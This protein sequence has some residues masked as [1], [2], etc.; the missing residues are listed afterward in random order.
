MRITNQMKH[1]QLL[2]DLDKL[3]NEVFLSQQVLNTGKEVSKPS[4]DPAK[5]RRIMSLESSKSRRS[6]YGENIDSGISK[7]GYTSVQLQR[8]DDL[9]KEARTIALQGANGSTGDSERSSLS[10]R[11]DHMILE[12]TSI[13]NSRIN[14]QYIFG[15]FNTQDAPYTL[16]S[17]P[18]SG[19][20]I[21]VQDRADNMDGVINQ[22][23]SSGEYVQTN[24]LGVEV[25]QTGDPGDDGDMFQVLIDLRDALKDGIG[26]DSEQLDPADPAFVPG[27]DTLYSRP[28]H[29]SQEV[30]AEALEKIDASSELIRTKVTIVGGTVKRLMNTEQVNEDLKLIEGEHLSKT[31]DADYTEWI[32]KY[33][34]QMLA[35]QQAMQVGSQVLNSSMVNFIR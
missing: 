9:M 18:A 8:A 15:G 16:I 30:I 27:V 24:V 23:S 3:Q 7:L 32:S 10:V 28:E 21:R 1:S 31:Q 17:D 5:A 33:Q 11:V 22:I 35:L 14:D 4:D 25:F 34:M 26:N 12:L 13:G 29:S 19:E 2:I 20:V 6:Q